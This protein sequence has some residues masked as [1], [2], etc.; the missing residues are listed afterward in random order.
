M[1]VSGAYGRDYT[2]GKKMK[3]AWRG[4]ADFIIR[5]GFSGDYGRYVNR[6]DYP[7]GVVMGR[8]QKDRKVTRLQ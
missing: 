3:A 4:G 5:D 7:A 1:T 2:S 8:Y 6:Q